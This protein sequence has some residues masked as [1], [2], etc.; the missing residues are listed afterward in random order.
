VHQRYAVRLR[1][2]PVPAEAQGA[3]DLTSQ[4]VEQ[5]G[6]SPADNR[7]RPTRCRPTGYRAAY[8]AEGED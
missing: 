7:R 3:G 1:E 6:G 8:A 4:F 2:P 5:L